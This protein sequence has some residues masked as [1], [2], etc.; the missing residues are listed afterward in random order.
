MDPEKAFNQVDWLFLEQTLIEI[1]YKIEIRYGEIFATWINALYKNPRSK[2]RLNSCCSDSFMVEGK[3]DSLSPILFI[4][5]IGSYFFFWD[6]RE[7]YG[8]DQRYILRILLF[9]AGKMRTLK[10]KKTKP[11]SITQWIQRMNKST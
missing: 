4:G 11:P 1:R 6:F 5:F 2:V 9:I 3:G 7:T 10:W 8:S